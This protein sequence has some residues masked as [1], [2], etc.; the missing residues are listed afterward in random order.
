[1]T[2]KVAL[3]EDYEHEAWDK[4]VN[5]QPSGTFCHLAGWKH[6]IEQGAGQACPYLVAKQDGDIVGV[7]PLS[8]K[9]HLLFGKALVS[10][11]FCVYGGPV[12]SEES[13]AQRLSEEAW[14]MATQTGLPVLEL[15]SEKACNPVGV[16]W[17][18]TVSAATF[19]TEL[20]E[21]DEAQLLA[22]P[23]KQRAVVRKSL[24][25]DLLTNWEGGLELFY[26]LYARSVLALGTPVFPK[27]LFAA[28][29]SVFKDDV[30]IQITS[31]RDGNAV[32]GLMSFYFRDTVMPYYAGGNQH[33]R[34]LGAHDYMYYQLMLHARQRGCSIFDF[35]RSKLDSGPYRFKKNWGFEPTPLEYQ[36][37]LQEGTA[38]PNVSQQSGLFGHLSKVWRKLP[39][40]LSKML[41]PS[42]ARHLG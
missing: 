23:R 20:A 4:F 11:M 30:E 3:F 22:V 25:N 16:D 21:D 39:L 7:L 24:K 14:Q 1:M 41:G 28:L 34:K 40:P 2:V 42:V 19:R 31:D 29:K 18:N 5:S 36:V 27:K 13:V 33:T 10:N 9:K 37:R 32:A 35:G 38:P 6:V 17:V 15:R 26:D 12:S 8:V